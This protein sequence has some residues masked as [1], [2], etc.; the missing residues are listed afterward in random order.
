MS[1]QR[2]QRCGLLYNDE[3]CSTTCPHRGIGF[4]VV[5]DCALCVCD[6]QTANERSAQFAKRE[7]ENEAHP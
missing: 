4:C 6:P 5:C 1:R 2:C 7:R 3:F